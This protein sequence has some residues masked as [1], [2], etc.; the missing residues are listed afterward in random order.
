MNNNDNINGKKNNT[1]MIMTIIMLDI[2]INNND[3]R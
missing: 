3:K 2:Y 1:I